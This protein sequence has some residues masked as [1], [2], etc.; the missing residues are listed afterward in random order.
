MARLSR[1]LSAV[2]LGIAMTAAVGAAVVASVEN[3]GQ[4]RRAP[5]HLVESTTSARVIVKFKANSAVLST[6]K[7]I[8][9]A[10]SSSVRAGLRAASAL[11]TRL[12]LTLAD[13]RALGE[14]T[15]VLMA[16]GT[17]SAKLAA[18]LASQSDVEWVQVDHRRFVQAAP[19]TDPLYG[20]S[21]STA[22]APT[23]PVAGQWYLRAPGF[24]A[25]GHNLVSSIN[26]EPAWAITHGATSIVIGDVDTG[27]TSH[28]DLNSKLFPAIFSGTTSSTPYGYDFVGYGENDPA[29]SANA[30][31][32]AND[33]SLADPDPSDPGDYVTAAENSNKSGP[34]YKCNDADYPDDPPGSAVAVDSSWHGTQTA[35]ILA[36]ATNNAVGMA[37]VGYNAMVVPARALGKCGGYDSDIIAAA[38]WAGGIA[39]SG[40]PTNLHPARVINMSLGGSGNCATDA[41]AYID[42]LTSLRNNNVVVV[43]AAGNDDGLVVDVPANCQPDPSDTDQT[44]I[45]VAVAGLRHAGDKVGYS[46][47][48][49]QVTVSAPA[50]NCVNG[51]I[52]A[53]SQCL[54]PI[55]TTLNSGTTAPVSGGGIYSDGVNYSAGTSFATPLVAGTVGLMLSAAPNLTNAQVISILKSTARTFPTVSDTTPQPPVCTVPVAEVDDSNGNVITPASAPQAECICT[56][57]TCGAG[58][59]DAG[60]AVAAAAAL[61]TGAAP[62]YTAPTAV[63]APTSTSVVA[64]STVT[65]SGAG[66]TVGSSGAALTYQWS[67]PDADTFITLGSTTGASLVVTGAAAGT[68][69]VQLIVTD[70]TSGLTSTATV[71]VT[72]TSAASSSG[73]GGGAANPAWL[74]ALAVAGLLLRPRVR[75][76]RA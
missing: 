62:S 27:I 49:P 20:D 21:L 65:L 56:T 76:P 19:V 33:G 9:A 30:I 17:T 18:T 53:T 40:V 31:A 41:P 64:G 69:Q 29:D 72:V 68:G 63:V 55:L 46:D 52:T 37:G 51:T 50:G 3:S 12:G 44:P 42:A 4:V 74:V 59:L 16:G 22:V 43:V 5:S 15:Q 2:G 23:G 39:V 1:V 24:D 11:S 7:S 67:I 71:S 70:P 26:V 25:S 32:T 75:R 14:R 57:S 58:M 35:G 66:S 36:A 34:F 60:K 28:P 8:A 61:S 10:G 6:K 54:Y 73:G 48:G 13:G 47:I 38:Q 45:V